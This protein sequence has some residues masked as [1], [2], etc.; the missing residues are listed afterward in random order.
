MKGHGTHCSAIGLTL[1]AL[2][3]DSDSLFAHLTASTARAHIAAEDSRGPTASSAS[4]ACTYPAKGPIATT[5]E[6]MS[7]KPLMHCPATTIQQAEQQSTK[8]PG[9]LPPHTTLHYTT[10]HYTLL[11]AAVA[12]APCPRKPRA[13]HAAA[14]AAATRP[15]SQGLTSACRLSRDAHTLSRTRPS[16]PSVTRAAPAGPSTRG[17]WTGASGFGRVGP[18][19]E[20]PLLVCSGRRQLRSRT[21][22]ASVRNS[23]LLT[24]AGNG[25]QHTHSKPK[26]VCR[27]G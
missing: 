17:N 7:R 19:P 23:T 18:E 11:H 1:D 21:R 10:L 16:R 22:S 27:R 5:V 8:E 4:A 2:T 13:I 14:A 25:T 3:N 12:T 15:K 9:A 26:G 6:E 24:S 20:A